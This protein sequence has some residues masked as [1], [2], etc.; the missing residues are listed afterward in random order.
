MSKMNIHDN[1]IR[2]FDFI[3]EK[4]K[5]ALDRRYGCFV[6]VKIESNFII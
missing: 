1:R 5:K 6:F 3:S 4:D 2:E